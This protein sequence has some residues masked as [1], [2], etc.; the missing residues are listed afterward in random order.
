MYTYIYVL[1]TISSP[2]RFKITNIFLVHTVLCYTKKK[3]YTYVISFQKYIQE[4]KT[5][6][7]FYGER[8][9]HY[10]DY[11]LRYFQLYKMRN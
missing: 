8:G 6:N 7:M 9:I 11:F 5:L 1:S 2:V 4:P 10:C 3:L